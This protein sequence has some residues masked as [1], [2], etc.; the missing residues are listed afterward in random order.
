[1]LAIKGIKY[2]YKAVNLLKQENRTEEFFKV[3]PMQ[4][5]PTLV[6]DG[7]TFAESVAIMEYLEETRPDPPLLPKDPVNRAKVRQMVEI[8]VSDI[9]PV[10]NLRVLEKVGEEK[11]AE[12]AKHWITVGFEALET[13]LSKNSTNGQYCFGSSLTLADCVLVP[14]VYGAR[15]YNVDLTK[16]PIISKIEAHLNTLEAFKQ[17]H[18]DVQPDTPPP[19]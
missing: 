14:Q 7:H 11:K 2:E 9:Q 19:S 17:A 12:W 8:I 3:N 1:V 5:I 6:I 15:R 10:Q 4:A 16:F 13:V 18:A